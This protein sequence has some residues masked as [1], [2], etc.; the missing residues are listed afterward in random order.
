MRATRP[1]MIS[2]FE[3]CRTRHTMQPKMLPLCLQRGQWARKTAQPHNSPTAQQHNSSAQGVN[4]RV[5]GERVVAVARDRGDRRECGAGNSIA[6][7]GLPRR[8]PDPASGEHE[9]IAMDRT[10]TGSEQDGKADR[11]QSRRTGALS[12]GACRA[13]KCID[14]SKITNRTLCQRA[15]LWQS[16]ARSRRHR[17]TPRS[18]RTP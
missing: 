7:L 13:V 5:D 1:K 4:G 3:S 9:A 15:G 16:A 12:G 18:A 2:K 10:A 6:P 17:R 11:Q 8:H 14:T